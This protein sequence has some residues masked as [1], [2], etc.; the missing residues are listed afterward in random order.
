MA[1]MV[2][3]VQLV[4]LLLICLMVAWMM[5]LHWVRQVVGALRCLILWTPLP[6]PS[7]LCAA[8]M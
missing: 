4:V 1:L 3:V 6:L 7:G 8:D 5:V 2:V